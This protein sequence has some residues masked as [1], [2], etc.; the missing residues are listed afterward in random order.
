MS[1]HTAFWSP[2][3]RTPDRIMLTN[4]ICSVISNMPIRPTVLSKTMGPRYTRSE[5]AMRTCASHLSRLIPNCRRRMS[6]RIPRTR[7]KAH[8]TETR[9]SRGS[10]SLSRRS[11]SSAGAA[12]QSL[13]KTSEVAETSEVFNA[14]ARSRSRSL[15]LISNP[16]DNFNASCAQ[17]VIHVWQRL[18]SVDSTR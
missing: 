8:A 15:R 11:S 7:T 10:G 14:H 18:H 1:A 2:S 4:R 3:M 9:T 12:G 13:S 17:T 6:P 5:E 16:N